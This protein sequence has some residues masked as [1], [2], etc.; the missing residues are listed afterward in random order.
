MNRWQVVDNG[1]YAGLECNFQPMCH[2]C[3]VPMG[4]SCIK[5][6][7]FPL[8]E[9]AYWERGEINGYA[10]DVEV[11]CP[12]CGYWETF[13]VAVDKEHWKMLR[14]QTEELIAEEI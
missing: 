3:K 7:H 12:L 14:I 8:N 11:E 2:Y 9:P 10:V 4:N 6:L 1:T 13:G 5:L